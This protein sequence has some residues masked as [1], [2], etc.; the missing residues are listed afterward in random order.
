MKHQRRGQSPTGNT[1]R[2]RTANTSGKQNVPASQTSSNVRS[3]TKS[4]QNKTGGSSEN[5][6][7]LTSAGFP[8][9]QRQILTAQA[10]QQLIQIQQKLLVPRLGRR[11]RLRSLLGRR[12]LT[13]RRRRRARHRRGD[14]QAAPQHRWLRGGPRHSAQHTT[15]APPSL[16]DFPGQV[17]IRPPE[18]RRTSPNHPAR[19]TDHTLPLN[20][21]QGI[22]PP[23]HRSSHPHR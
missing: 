9:K 7:A 18:Q 13:W 21:H 16:K 19:V 5:I 15:M 14:G 17:D 1:K 22:D 6:A 12:L 4:E 10:S 23:N 2:R 11:F 20:P 3:D 8:N